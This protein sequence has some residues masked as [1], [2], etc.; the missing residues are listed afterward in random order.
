[1]NKNIAHSVNEIAA[2]LQSKYN[3]FNH[4]NKRNPLNELLL[5]LCSIKRSEQVYMRAYKSI[6]LNFPRF[7][8]I[9]KASV[10]T[11]TDKINWGGLQN[12]KA[13]SLKSIFEAIESK[14]GKPTLSPLKSLSDKECEEFLTS[15]PMVGKKVAR[16]IMLYSLNRQVFPVDSHCWRIA[17]RV[18]WIDGSF[19]TKEYSPSNQDLLQ[20]RIPPQLRYTLHVNML[21]LGRDIC[22]HSNP[23]CNICPIKN[24]CYRTL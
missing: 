17:S 6:K 1:M 10:R 14:Y 21:S 3:G 19:K 16:C 13:S 9:S 2:A 22:T 15:L 8:M 12:Q 7:E 11:L 18:G 4:F 20:D 23:K 5:I 24:S